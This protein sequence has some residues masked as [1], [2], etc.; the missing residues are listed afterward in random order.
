M[1]QKRSNI[2]KTWPIL[3]KTSKYVVVAAHARKQSIP[4]LL[5]LR[6]ILGIAR[7]RKEARYILLNNNVK[8]NNKIRKNDAFPVQVFD[9][10]QLEEISEKEAD[11]KIIKI[12]GKKILGKG[13]IQMN[14]QDGR[15]FLFKDKF[16]VGDSVV[17]NTKQNKIE[18]IL[19]LEKNAKVEI[20][21][22]KH[23]GEKGVLK[24][25]IDF[26]KGK[27]IQ[28]ELKINGES[29]KIDLPPKMILII[30]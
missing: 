6:D 4:L 24:E 8:I 27:K 13:Q 2:P 12:S 15:N 14:L 26:K 23:A 17:V 18:K 1:Y 20:I 10:I 3:K 25:I 29:K 5:I 30:E 7:T 16:G 9:K 22:G 19:N 11:K 21:A 28:V